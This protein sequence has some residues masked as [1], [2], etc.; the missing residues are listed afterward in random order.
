MALDR[1]SKSHKRKHRNNKGIKKNILFFVK[2]NNSLERY[3]SRPAF[4]YWK[5]DKMCCPDLCAANDAIS[6]KYWMKNAFN[7]PKTRFSE[8]RF[9]EILDLMNKI[10]LPFSYSTLYPD[11]I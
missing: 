8:P 5:R 9:S 10:Q 3:I 11:S 7:N 1:I 6:T 4:Y 2:K